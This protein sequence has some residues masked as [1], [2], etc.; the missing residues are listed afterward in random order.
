MTVV[1]N[2]LTAV[3]CVAPVADVEGVRALLG[4]T[5]R[6]C[7]VVDDDGTIGLTAVPAPRHTLLA[8]A[9]PL[10]PTQLGSAAFRTA[11]GTDLAYMAGSMAGGV[12]SEDLVIAMAREGLLASFGAAGLIPDRIERALQRFIAEV[13]DRPWACNLIHSPHEIELERATVDLCLRYGVRCVEASAFF[14]V[15]PSIVRYRVAGLRRGPDGVPIAENRVIAKVSRDQ[16]AQR[17]LAPPPSEIVTGLLA[18]GAITAEQAE[19]AM[20]VPMCDDLTAEADSGGHTDR[21]P[22]AVLLP[23]ML[24]QRDRSG[25][26]CVRVGAAGGLGTP[27]AVWSAF[28]A[29]ADYVVTGSVNQSCCE[30]G[31]SDAVR[32]LLAEAEPTDCDMAPAADMFELG[33]QLQVLKRGT[34]F[35]MRAKKL[36]ALYA[37]HASLED[38]PALQLE[39]LETKI[40][41]QSVDE[42]WAQCEEYFSRRDPTQLERARNAPKRRMALVFR[43]YLGMASRW[44]SVGEADRV[45]DY[46][47]WCGPSMGAF[48]QWVA[49]TPLAHPAGREVATVARELMHGAAVA[50]RICALRAA[51]TVLPAGVEHR[52]GGGRS[53]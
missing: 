39:H 11:H 43:W 27:A 30:S 12:A 48:N 5:D 17:F 18:E 51:G 4:D 42:V 38:I 35:P 32:A 40:L 44:A 20:L 23:A 31:T 8:V 41:G 37:S 33:V 49:G 25:A 21:Q 29:G 53:S 50:G 10:P 45:Q 28:A 14:D 26:H 6:P 36:Y 24:R 1:E 7:Y 15:T 34:F 52:P 13:P 47:I 9:G 22:L 2:P 3:D 19:L 16:V 46:Q